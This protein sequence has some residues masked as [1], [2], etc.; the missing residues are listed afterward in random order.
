MR[1]RNFQAPE[2]QRPNMACR[3]TRLNDSGPFK[4]LIWRI[5]QEHPF[6]PRPRAI[7]I[8]GEATSGQLEFSAVA[9]TIRRIDS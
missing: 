9:G 1:E 3:Q 4:V 5:T 2:R 7:G 8:G 6:F